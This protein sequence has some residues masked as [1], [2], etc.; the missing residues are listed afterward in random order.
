[1]IDFFFYISKK[2]K[3]NYQKKNTNKQTNKSKKKTHH[4]TMKKEEI[5]SIVKKY[6]AKK[7]YSTKTNYNY[8]RGLE[9]KSEIM[10]RVEEIQEKKQIYTT[11]ESMK[12]KPKK[13]S[14]YFDALQKTFHIDSLFTQPIQCPK[15]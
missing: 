6:K 3:K 1:M 15:I 11:D 7:G 8:F 12:S 2:E 14:R 13:K 5:L 10:K 9:K 4:H